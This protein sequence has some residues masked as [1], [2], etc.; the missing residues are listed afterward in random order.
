[1]AGC[2]GGV[3]TSAADDRL[4][5]RA[6]VARTIAATVVRTHDSVR[7]VVPTV[8]QQLPRLK[9]ARQAVQTVQVRTSGVEVLDALIDGVRAATTSSW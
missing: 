3:V 5:D 2:A 4:G 8:Q 9:G 7:Q 6:Y 1:M